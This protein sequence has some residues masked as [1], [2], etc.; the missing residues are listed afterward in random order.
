[1]FFM[2]YLPGMGWFILKRDR[3]SSYP[4]SFERYNS[5]KGWENFS[6][7]PL[8]HSNNP[9][10]I[11][12]FHNQSLLE[13]FPYIQLSKD[14]KPRQGVNSC[15]A[16]SILYFN[17]YTK[18][19]NTHCKLDGNIILPSQ[20]IYPLLTSKNFKM[21]NSIPNR[22]ALLPYNTNGKPIE[23]EQLKTYPNLYNY[24]LQHKEKLEKRKGIM[25]GSWIKRGFWW[26]LLGVG[27]YNFYPYKIVWE[28]YGKR[29]FQPKI[30][31]GKW[32]AS[33]SLQCYVPV[34]TEKEA[35]RILYDL[36]HSNLE[37][38]LLSFKMEG[39][40]NWA[41]PGRIKKLMKFVD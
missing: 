20:F 11:I 6:A 2:E 1:M 33:Q 3:Q 9:L 34:K 32:Q 38:Y 23:L 4:I 7:Q 39:T 10:S 19:D 36:Q 41:Q 40:M 14:S 27:T 16:N 29:L 8:L 5:S 28:S 22:W 26:S 37:K 15:G 35:K 12:D 21:D 30:F 24:L 25:I 31:E 13:D 17:S 18:I